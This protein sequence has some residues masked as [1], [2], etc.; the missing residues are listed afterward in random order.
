MLVVERSGGRGGGGIPDRKV[1]EK[2]TENGSSSQIRFD[3]SREDKGDHKKRRSKVIN[4]KDEKR[5]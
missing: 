2:I 5:T 1:M 4:Y 3:A